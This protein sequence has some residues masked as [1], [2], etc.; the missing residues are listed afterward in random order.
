MFGISGNARSCDMFLACPLE[1]RELRLLLAGDVSFMTE[2]EW[3]LAGLPASIWIVI[4]KLN[5][6]WKHSNGR[7]WHGTGGGA[8]R[9]PL[10]ISAI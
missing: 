10:I 1:A 2:A 7:E 6:L 4:C 3:E 5:I 8:Y 9:F